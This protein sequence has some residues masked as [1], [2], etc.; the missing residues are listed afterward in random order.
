LLTTLL[1]FKTQISALPS[2][3]KQAE[4]TIQRFML[5]LLPVFNMIKADSYEESKKLMQ[6]YLDLL[7]KSDTFSVPSK[8]TSLLHMYNACKQGNKSLVFISLVE[9]C[10]REGCFDILEVRAREVVYESTSWDLKEVERRDL[11]L[12]IARC[13]D[14]QKDAGAFQ[15]LYAF[16][17][18]LQKVDANEL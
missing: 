4:C 15:V 3:L 18:T 7:C 12:R 6:Q 9:L 2:Q 16:L 5:Y 11:Y 10:C 1:T 13:L 8:V 14:S 17:Q